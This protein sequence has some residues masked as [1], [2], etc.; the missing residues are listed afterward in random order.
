ME[1]LGLRAGGSD[2]LRTVCPQ[3]KSGGSGES[4][5]PG[6]PLWALRKGGE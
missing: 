6:Q 5:E 4:W 2:S 3:E 1:C